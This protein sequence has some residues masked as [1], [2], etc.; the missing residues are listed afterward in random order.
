MGSK[1]KVHECVN[2]SYYINT[3]QQIVSCQSKY[4]KS[5]ERKTQTFQWKYDKYKWQTK[6]T[7]RESQI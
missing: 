4:T 5:Y 2:L 6:K 1:R 7:P 3:N